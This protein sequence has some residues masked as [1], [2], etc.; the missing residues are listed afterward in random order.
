MY[1]FGRG[2]VDGGSQIQKSIWNV[3]I[4]VLQFC[5]IYVVV[6]RSRR[7]RKSVAIAAVDI[8][9]TIIIVVISIQC[10]V[11]FIPGHA[12]TKF[13]LLSLLLL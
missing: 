9:I 12:S 3:S 8:I 4:F 13:S 6:V 5:S 1:C 7:R 2:G 11:Q 10:L